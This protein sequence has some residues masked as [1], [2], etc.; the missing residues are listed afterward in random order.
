MAAQLQFKPEDRTRLVSALSGALL[1]AAKARSVEEA[2]FFQIITLRDAPESA[3]KEL[4]ELLDV[5]RSIPAL[6]QFDHARQYA[7]G[8]WKQIDFM[9]LV[10]WLVSHGQH[11]GPERA[12][13]GDRRFYDGTHYLHA[14]SFPVTCSCI[15]RLSHLCS[16]RLPKE[17]SAHAVFS[18]TRMGDLLSVGHL[19]MA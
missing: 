17:R 7:L 16:R 11:V 3:L 10:G 5:V 2:L 1:V 18:L 13:A 19:H 6:D 4:K 15:R 8:Y 9:F 12:V 14:L